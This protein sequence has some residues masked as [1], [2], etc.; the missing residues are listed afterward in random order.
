M[1]GIEFGRNLAPGTGCGPGLPRGWK[2]ICLRQWQGP[3]DEG[4][5]RDQ[6]TSASYARRLRF[7]QLPRAAK[8]GCTSLWIP[9]AGGGVPPDLGF[10]LRR[11]TWEGPRFSGLADAYDDSD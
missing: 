3:D 9:N 1:R 4:V 6:R 11:R 8:V 7:G 5:S 10:E 2:P